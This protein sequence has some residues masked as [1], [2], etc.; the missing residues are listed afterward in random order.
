MTA[1][2]QNESLNDLVT[3][4]REIDKIINVDNEL[5]QKDNPIYHDPLDTRFLDAHFYAPNK[6]VFGIKVST[7][8]SNIVV[9]WGMS[10]LFGIFLYFDLFTLSVHKISF[11][12]RKISEK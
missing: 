12:R 4:R 5:V 1:K 6:Y 2:Y 7:F 10:I 8:W 9:L 3:N 11:L